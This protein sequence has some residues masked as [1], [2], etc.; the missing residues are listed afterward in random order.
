MHICIELDKY[1]LILNPMD[2]IILEFLFISLVYLIAL[3]G[4]GIDRVGKADTWLMGN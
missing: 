4:L 2:L 3:T 1:G